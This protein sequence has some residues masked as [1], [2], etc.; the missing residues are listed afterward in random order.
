MDAS[1]LA[2][3]LFVPHPRPG[4]VA[5]PR[6]IERLSA[7]LD[8]GLILVS[9]PAGYG[10]TTILTQW[11]AQNKPAIAAAWISLDQ[12]DNDPVRFWDYFIAALRTVRPA[13]GEAASAMLHSAQGYATESLLISLINDLS[14]IS[15]D[16][17]LVLDDYHLVNSEGVHTGVTFLLD[18]LPPRMHVLVA[19]R[20]DPPLRLAHFRGRGAMV[21]I[22]ADDLRF[23]GEE[24]AGLLRE[25]LGETLSLEQ[26]ASL[27]A[28][29]EGWPVGLKM[30]AL[31]MRGQKNVPRLIAAFAGSHRYVGDYLIEEVLRWQPDEVR[32]FLLNT[33]VLERLTAP[34]CDTITEGTG[35]QT[36]LEEIEQ[37]NLFLVQL[38]ESR[39][40]YRYHHLFAEHLRHRLERAS[41]LDNVTRLHRR[42]SQWY[43]DHGFPDD[44]IHHALAARDW[45][46][47]VGLIGSVAEGRM[48]QGEMTTVLGWLQSVPDEMLRADLNVYG[49]YGHILVHTGRF[50]SAETVLNYLERAAPEDAE[51]QGQVAA[52]R[53][54]QAFRRDDLIRSTKLGRRALALLP[55]DNHGLRA[56][57][58]WCLG[59]ALYRLGLYAEARPAL[60][61]SI[62]AGKLVGD[63]LSASDSLSYLWH[64]GQLRRMAEVGQQ[65]IALAG[66]SP[67]SALG[68]LTLSRAQ[69]EWNDLDEAARN[70]AIAA[71]LSELRGPPEVILSSHV[72]LA[73]TRV[74]RGDSEAAIESMA[75]IGSLL[76]G[77]AARP[78]IRALA[79][80]Y[81]ALLALRLSDLVGASKWEE[82]LL[83]LADA[84]PIEARN[85]PARL[86]IARGEKATAKKWLQDCNREAAQLDAQGVIV[87]IRVYQ[88]LAAETPA[89]AL[90]FLTEALKLGEPEGFVRTFVDEGKLLKPLLRRASVHGITPQYTAKLLNIIEAEERR[91]QLTSGT[92]PSHQAPG[93]VSDR[94]LEILRLVASG[95]TNR[96]IAARLIVTQGTVKVHLHNIS[97]KLNAR[98]RTQAVTRAR[99][100]KLI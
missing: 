11:I 45:E 3:K 91:R 99:E 61:I 97:E 59:L 83:P 21:E 2:T 35:S 57:A 19:T 36:L 64:Q 17:V 7:A 66:R 100:L 46:R 90:T 69:Y 72:F 81:S 48:K 37:A 74:A 24:A 94:E 52:D 86:L 4:L 38:D 42:A 95:L 23:T 80:S 1:L 87:E 33:S 63:L 31:S 5:R 75:K 22:G 47:V 34:L 28:R 79:I 50:D 89:E 88:A 54:F 43:E 82:R 29:T 27:N 84:L 93:I 77:R 76:E 78:G 8:C 44:A 12:G 26:I 18:H 30:A 58:A 15:R 39:R 6:L 62:D 32:A 13:A 65:I 73:R 16:V 10:K 56:R 71:E 14:D 92:G 41:G 67:A 68:W 85:I 55:K 9:A 40:W 60:S 20:A 49:Q 25:V 70:Q 98:S 53:A 96:Q 51:L